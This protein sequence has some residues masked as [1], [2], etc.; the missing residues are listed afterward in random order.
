MTT[1]KKPRTLALITAFVI[2]I[3]L[4]PISS[5]SSASAN[6]PQGTT[7]DNSTLPVRVTQIGGAGSLFGML[8]WNAVPGATQY[9]IHKTGS[10]RPYWR[11]FW[12]TP[13]SM[14]KLEVVDQPGAIAVYRVTAVVNS[15]EVVIG[16]FNYRPRK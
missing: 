13:A 12:I 6:S 14:T 9:I 4:V 16:R 5:S 8:E 1:I 15:R 11:L 10:I 3:A 7:T 2:V